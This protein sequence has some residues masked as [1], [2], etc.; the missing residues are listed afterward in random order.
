MMFRQNRWPLKQMPDV[1][2][3]TDFEFVTPLSMQDC[4]QR[5][6]QAIR[7]QSP[8]KKSDIFEV[9]QDDKK[10]IFF[11]AKFALNRSAC[12]LAGQVEAVNRQCRVSGYSGI[13]I[14]TF[15][16]PLIFLLVVLILVGLANQLS[17]IAVVLLFAA[18]LIL[19]GMVGNRYVRLFRQQLEHDIR[20]LLGASELKAS[21]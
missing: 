3:G 8:A 12:Y 16:L 11:A 5:L 17:L 20:D 6:Q 1:V 10:Q 2:F 4:L 13:P 18:V 21:D 19:T 14:V 9:S 7:Q 15:I